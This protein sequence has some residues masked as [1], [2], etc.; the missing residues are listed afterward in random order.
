MDQIKKKIASTKIDWLLQKNNVKKIQKYQGSL[1]RGRD[2]NDGIEN[3]TFETFALNN[4]SIVKNN[5][6]FCG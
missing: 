4:L 2:S 5:V 1:K 6:N 3:G